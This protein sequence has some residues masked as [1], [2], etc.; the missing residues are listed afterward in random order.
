MKY[1]AI[2]F[3]YSGVI[4]QSSGADFTLN[5]CKILD[6]SRDDFFDI[7]LKYNYLLNTTNIDKKDFWKKLLKEWNKE[8]KEKEFFAF[9]DSLK[10]DDN[11]NYELIDFIKQLK[12]LNYKIGL[13]SNNSSRLKNILKE[14]GIDFLF[15]VILVSEDVG[16]I[17]PD[18]EIFEILCDKLNICPKELVFVDDFEKNFINVDKIGF[19]PVLYINFKKLKDDF[20]KLGII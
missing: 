9:I 14:K 8:S 16:F 6:I 7:Y 12:K 13:L 11:L 4:T 3:D 18:I 15:D 1:K 17:K 2:A 10:S 19:T 20:K 5:V